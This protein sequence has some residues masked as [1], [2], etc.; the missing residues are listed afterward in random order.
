MNPAILSDGKYMYSI[1]YSM[2]AETRANVKA[3]EWFNKN[4]IE[5]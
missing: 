3:G 2:D 1:Q 5:K 4:A